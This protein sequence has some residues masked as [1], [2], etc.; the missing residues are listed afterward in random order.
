MKKEQKKELATIL[1]ALSDVHDLIKEYQNEHGDHSLAMQASVLVGDHKGY[2]VKSVNV[3]EIGNLLVCVEYNKAK[4]VST[5]AERSS[6]LDDMLGSILDRANH[7]C[8]NDE[9]PIHGSK[10]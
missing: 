10:K 9:C 8:E 3:G 1:K 7:D 2:T 4:F 5:F 6:S